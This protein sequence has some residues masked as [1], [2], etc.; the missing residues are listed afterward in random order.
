MNSLKQNYYNPSFSHIYIE[1]EVWDHPRTQRILDFFPKAVKIEIAHYKDVFCR[2]KQDISLQNKAPMLI[3]AKKR[4]PFVYSGA[5]V[6][7]DFGEE[8]FYYT[9]CAMNCI[10]DCEYCYMK[11]M[12]PSGNL[13]FFVNLEDTFQ[14]IERRLMEH[15]M[16][17]CISYDTDLMAMER[18]TGFVED[19]VSFAKTHPGLIVECRTKCSGTEFW[20][21]VPSNKQVVFAFT[22]SPKRI[23][24]E[25]EWKT[26]PLQERLL[27]VREAMDHGFPVRLCFDPM[28]YVSDWKKQYG[29]VIDQAASLLDFSRI[30]DASIGSFRISQDYLKKMRRVMPMSKTVQFPFENEK[31]VYHYP[32]ALMDEMEAYL[33]QL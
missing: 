33:L 12:Y 24:E 31:G 7:Q 30:R 17:V 32:T 19:W 13:V 11:G 26:P 1:E 6:C 25:C 23:V 22:L 14:E 4:V 29:D 5:A 18:I 15:G 28:I 8:H 20:K 27:A 9:S 3:L 21:R 2:K 16:Y 10:Y